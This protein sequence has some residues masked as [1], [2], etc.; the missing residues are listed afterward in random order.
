MATAIALLKNSWCEGAIMLSA[1]GAAGLVVVVKV[2]G[3]N[4]SGEA[5]GSVISS[6]DLGSATGISCVSK[7]LL[8]GRTAGA[9]LWSHVAAKCASC[10]FVNT[11][12]KCS[13]F[14]SFSLPLR[15]KVGVGVGVGVR[16]PGTWIDEVGCLLHGSWKAE[17]LQVS[18]GSAFGNC[19]RLR[20]SKF[21]T[22]LEWVVCLVSGFRVY[23]L[24]RSRVSQRVSWCTVNINHG[25]VGRSV[26]EGKAAGGRWGRFPR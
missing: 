24:G 8:Y 4:N 17:R 19:R 14:S 20:L 11:G 15:R 26:I 3:M 1:V 13:F 25:C 21:W 2:R 16:V 10:S 18:R 5:V 22:L 7:I 23:C 6:L 9:C 12:S